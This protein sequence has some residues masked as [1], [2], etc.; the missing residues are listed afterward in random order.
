M[1]TVQTRGLGKGLSALIAEVEKTVEQQKPAHPPV[2]G[3]GKLEGD[4]RD[5]Y[6]AQLEAGKFQPRGYFNEEA[7]QELSDSIKRNGVMQPIVVRRKMGAAPD[8]YEII[9][10]ER[11]WRAAKM[12]GLTVIPA[13]VKEL[14]D[15][16]AMELS[17]I[18]NVQRA[19]LSPL[20]EAGGYQRL[21]AEFRYTQDALSQTVG[22]SRSHIANLLRLLSL[23]QSIRDL[24]EKGTI[25]MGHARS[26]L[27]V[28]EPVANDIAREI[29]DQRLS[30]RQVEAR[31]RNTQPDG[32]YTPPA[33][34]PRQPRAAA[35]PAYTGPKDPD[36][37]ALEET[38]SA[39]F[40]M[41]VEIREGRNGAQ[42]GELAISYDSLSQLDSILRR[43]GG[44][45]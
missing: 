41:K 44:G 31:V 33:A 8:R 14:T 1:V 5:L 6:L 16:Q 21:I 10:G 27:N 42:G 38:L 26:L 3:K 20:E 36:I 19:D 34:T 28:S 29:V 45:L 9:A 37:L 32:T 40:G 35:A 11:R 43:L 17:L 22:K 12:A 23:P 2:E 13:L 4:I 25:T 39:D 18:E 30:V 24:L 7:L 15:A